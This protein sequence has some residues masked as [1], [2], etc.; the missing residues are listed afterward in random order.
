MSLLPR[1]ARVEGNGGWVEKPLNA[2]ESGET[3]LA[4]PGERIPVD[5]VV[6]DGGSEVDE[7]MLTGEP[8]P[9][10]FTAG[11]QILIRSGPF[12]GMRGRILRRK[13]KTRLVVTLELIQSAMLLEL[14]AAEAQLAS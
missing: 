12:A 9:E 14:D 7:S 4:R 6:I 10:S 3:V 1:T 5:G 2:V 8:M 13:G 11:K